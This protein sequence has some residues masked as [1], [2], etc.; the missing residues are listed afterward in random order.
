VLLVDIKLCFSVLDPC[1]KDTHLKRFWGKALHTDALKAAEIIV[2]A[3]SYILGLSSLMTLTCLQFKERHVMLYGHHGAP[4]SPKKNRVGS[5]VNVLLR[6]LSSDESD[7]EPEE[8][9]VDPESPWTREFRLYLD[10]V[11]IIPESM[12]IVQWWGASLF[13]RSCSFADSRWMSQLNAYQYPVW[14]SLARDYLSIMATSV[15]SER[16]FSAAALTITKR[17]N[18]LKADVVE[19]IQVLRMLYNRDL[20]FRTPPPSSAVEMALEELEDGEDV[21]SSS[22]GSPVWALEMSDVSDC[23]IL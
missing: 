16:A 9:M 17:R 10:A 5:K 2:C 8:V 12:S 1:Q 7:N 13:A 14:A 20:L 15:S 19:A 22:R 3:S 21:D 18:R 23:D 6:E 11:T 4:S